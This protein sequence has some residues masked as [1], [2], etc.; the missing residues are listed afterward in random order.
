MKGL[1]TVLAVL[2]VVGLAFFLYRAPTA[3]PEMT[4][5]EIA[6]HEAEVIQEIQDRTHS[7]WEA[8]LDG[9]APA[10]ASYWTS[11]ALML[12]P[13]VR[14]TGEEL[15]TFMEG[16]LEAVDYLDYNFEV[17]EWFIHGDVAYSIA[18][19]D[20][21]FVVEGQE[22]VARNYGFSRWE[23]VDGVWMMDRLVAGPRDAPEEG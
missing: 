10:V 20:E 6:Q 18:S 17:L 19:Y 3:P 8:V 22:M 16:I 11:D 12:E 4:E 15:P 2:V 5:A 13:G 7:F 23:K 21:T 9:D 1:I 14:V